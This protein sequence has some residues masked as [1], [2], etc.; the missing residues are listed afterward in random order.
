MSRQLV[1]DGHNDLLARLYL[2]GG[3]TAANQFQAGRPSGHLDAHKAR[4]GGFGGGFFAIWVPSTQRGTPQ[5]RDANEA[6][7]AFHYDIPLSPMVPPMTP[8]V[9]RAS[10]WKRFRRCRTRVH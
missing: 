5:R 10:R 9:P 7:R 2:A 8:C 3:V 4:I 6:M 1:F